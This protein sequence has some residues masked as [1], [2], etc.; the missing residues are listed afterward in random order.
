MNSSAKCWIDLFDLPAFQGERRRFFGPARLDAEI[1]GLQHAHDV[2]VRV[3]SDAALRI[4][5]AGGGDKTLRPGQAIDS[6]DTTRVR[7]LE[8]VPG[9]G[10]E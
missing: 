7:R 9:R 8:V 5:M 1:L 4:E 10:A 6:L 3:G 2:S